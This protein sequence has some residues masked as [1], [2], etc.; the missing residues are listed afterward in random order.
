MENDTSSTS[1]SFFKFTTERPVAILMVV[2]G[3]VVFGFIS[4]LR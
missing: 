2:I 4:T 3:A 1:R